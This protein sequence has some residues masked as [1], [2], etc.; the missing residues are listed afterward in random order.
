LERSKG[1]PERDL[2][3]G[4]CVRETG[5]L[6]ERGDGKFRLDPSRTT[7]VPPPDFQPED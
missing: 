1:R 7:L 5:V 4:N 6:V 3:W 2:S